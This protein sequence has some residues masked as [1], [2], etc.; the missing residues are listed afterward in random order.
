M[1][2][3]SHQFPLPFLLPS[4]LVPFITNV[5]EKFA[6]HR[7]D[8]ILASIRAWINKLSKLP[9]KIASAKLIDIMYDEP[10][11]LFL[12]SSFTFQQYVTMLNPLKF[13]EEISLHEATCIRSAQVD[14]SSC[15]NCRL[16]SLW[17]EHGYRTCDPP[18]SS[19]ILLYLSWYFSTLQPACSMKAGTLP[20][21]C[22]LCHTY[23]IFN[24]CNNSTHSKFQ[25]PMGYRS[26]KFT[27]TCPWIYSLLCIL[28]PK[29]LCGDD[30]IF[31]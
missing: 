10:L 11:S 14:A 16:S 6:L 30:K 15:S 2:N 27:Q 4:I 20:L 29:I 26:V 18:S 23:V 25:N 13:Q 17:R 24:L 9:T 19:C 12:C 31:Y 21:G 8:L 3:Y 1:S 22:T 5:H 28:K 7:Q